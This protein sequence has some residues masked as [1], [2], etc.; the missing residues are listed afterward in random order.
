MMSLTAL[1]RMLQ[2]RALVLR[3]PQ[4]ADALLASLDWRGKRSNG[5]RVVAAYAAVL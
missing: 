4:C 3:P 5:A 1:A 2:M